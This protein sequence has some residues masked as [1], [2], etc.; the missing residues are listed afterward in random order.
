MVHPEHLQV[1]YT[2]FWVKNDLIS[3]LNDLTLSLSFKR[4]IMKKKVRKKITLIT[5]S[6]ELMIQEAVDKKEGTLEQI[7]KKFNVSLRSVCNI[8]AKYKK[9]VEELQQKEKEKPKAK[10]KETKEPKARKKKEEKPEYILLPE[11]V[12]K[13]QQEQQEET[14]AQEVTV[15][16]IGKESRDDAHGKTEK[17]VDT[18]L[19]VLQMRLE[20]EKLYMMVHPTALRGPME[21]KE[22]TEVLKAA[23]PFVLRKPMDTEDVTRGVKKLH[24]LFAEEFKKN[25]QHGKNN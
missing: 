22:L 8:K 6:I 4:L 1:F 9:A 15:E 5:P 3:P 23:A 13:Y 14:E 20:R 11:Q 16:E 21:T 17:M 18:A 25:Q 2:P 24:N 12:K 19:D 10:E 7:A